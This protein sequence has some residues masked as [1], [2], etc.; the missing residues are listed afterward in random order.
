M[1]GE[2]RLYLAGYDSAVAIQVNQVRWRL[3]VS[4]VAGDWIK[5][6]VFSGKKQWA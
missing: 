4:G 1:Q 2:Y 6:F 3:V 5:V